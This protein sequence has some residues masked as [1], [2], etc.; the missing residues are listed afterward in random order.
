MPCGVSSLHKCHTRLEKARY[1]FRSWL[2]SIQQ[3]LDALVSLHPSTEGCGVPRPS[4]KQGAACDN[5]WGLQRWDFRDLQNFQY[6]STLLD[7]SQLWVLVVK[8]TVGP[9]LLIWAET[10]NGWVTSGKPPWEL[11]PSMDKSGFNIFQSLAGSRWYIWSE[12]CQVYRRVL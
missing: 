11:L 12:H 5:G 4:V 6:W 9:E 7:W 1:C 8:E 2:Q 3:Q 10:W